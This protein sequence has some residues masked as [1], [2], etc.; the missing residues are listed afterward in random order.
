MRDQL[1]YEMQNV[2]FGV[3]GGLKHLASKD[4]QVKKALEVLPE[5]AGLLKKKVLSQQ[6]DGKTV[7][8][9]KYD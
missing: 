6:L 7:I 9:H 1:S 4:P 3:E 2:A 8:A 5:A